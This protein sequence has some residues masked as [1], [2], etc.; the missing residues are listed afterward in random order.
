MASDLQCP[1]CGP[2]GKIHPKQDGSM[3]CEVCG[4]TFVFQAG[5]AKLKDIGELD[6]LKTDVEDIKGSVSRL[7]EK[8]GDHREPPRTEEDL[9]DLQ[10]QLG[11]DPVVEDDDDED[12]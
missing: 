8:L 2:A 1:S 5:E 12:Y 11:D 3:A 7:A 10:Q 9:T 6:R 4:G